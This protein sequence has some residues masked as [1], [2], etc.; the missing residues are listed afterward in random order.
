[1]LCILPIHAA[2]PEEPQYF[3]EWSEGLDE[4]MAEYMAANGL[5]ERNFAVGYLYTG[6]GEY[7]YFNEDKMMVGGSLYKLPLNMRITEMV[8]NGERSWNDYVHGMPLAQAQRMSVEHSE[9]D[10]SIDLQHY[11]AGF[12]WGYYTTYRAELLKYSGWSED[13]I[14][15]G[16]YGSNTFSAE[17]MLKESSLRKA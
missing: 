6:T 16:Y 13:E 9:N 7:W 10:V 11:C 5:S 4:I 2:E 15:V 1:M 12:R 14:P 8:A 17:Y 3:T